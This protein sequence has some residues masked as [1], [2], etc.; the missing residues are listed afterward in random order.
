MVDRTFPLADV[1]QAHRYMEEGRS[2][3]RSC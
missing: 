2:T 1:V 3:A